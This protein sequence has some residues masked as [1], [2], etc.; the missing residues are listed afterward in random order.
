MAATEETRFTLHKSQ[1]TAANSGLK[2][3]DQLYRVY[4]DGSARG[5]KVG[6]PVTLRGITVGYV[7]DIKLEYDLDDSAFKIPVTI[8]FEPDRISMTGGQPLATG[9]S[10]EELVRRG[11]RA[12]LRTGNLLTG[13]MLIDL[14][15]YPDLE[16][17]QVYY[18]GEYAVLPTI[19]TAIDSLMLS[20]NEILLKLSEIPLEDIGRNLNELL[21]GAS[22]IANSASLRTSIGNM[23]TLTLQLNDTLGEVRGVITGLDEMVNNINGVVASPQIEQI[24]SNIDSASGKLD[25]TLG[26]VDRTVTGFQTD[27]DAYQ[28]LLRLMHELSAAARSLRQM[29]DYLERHPEALLQGKGK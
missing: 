23:E 18:E 9:P 22:E 5:L 16:A 2:R 8:E 25:Q 20:V 17:E 7:T 14:D 4:F 24:L 29:A 1:T 28:S 13:Q 12:Q 15:L 21:A 11:L 26:A 6:A 27:S 10:A 19:P 3:G